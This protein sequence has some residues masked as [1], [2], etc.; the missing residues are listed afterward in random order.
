MKIIKIK[1]IALYL[2]VVRFQI[3]CNAIQTATD[4]KAKV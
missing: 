2:G 3:K 4:Y 1:S